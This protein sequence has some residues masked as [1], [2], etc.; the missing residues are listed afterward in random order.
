M[1]GTSKGR[2]IQRIGPT[3][4]QLCANVSS[5]FSAGLVSA[6]PTQQKLIERLVG[7][8][9]QHP[10][11]TQM[12]FEGIVCGVPK[13]TASEVPSFEAVLAMRKSFQ[14]LGSQGSFWQN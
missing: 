7:A 12:I 3:F 14:H 4:G 10:N 13:G 9:R 1:T 5:E 11:G 8:A 2:P 6:S